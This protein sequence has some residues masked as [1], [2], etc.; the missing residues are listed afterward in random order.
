MMIKGKTKLAEAT[1]AIV[2][3]GSQQEIAALAY[4]LWMDRGCPE[5]SPHEDWFEAERQLQ[6]RRGRPS[7]T[8][9]LHMTVGS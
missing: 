2:E 7:R 8:T 6:E 9:R 4:Q 1:E 5:G 3:P